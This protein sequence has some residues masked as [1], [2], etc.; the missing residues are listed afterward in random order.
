M[1]NLTP[2]IPPNNQGGEDFQ[3]GVLWLAGDW[4]LA[5]GGA[6]RLQRAAA[7]R[8]AQTIVETAAYR[9]GKGSGKRAMNPAQALQPLIALAVRRAIR[10][11]PRSQPRAGAGL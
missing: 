6:G 10:P 8:G 3:G 1:S 7:G 4:L 2:A 5:I 11:R 9:A